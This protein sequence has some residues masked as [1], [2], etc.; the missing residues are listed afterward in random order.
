M[1]LPQHRTHLLILALLL[2]MI[3]AVACA[4][5]NAD[6]DATPL[7]DTGDYVTC[8]GFMTAEQIEEES[9]VSGLKDRV[10]VLDI[11][12]IPGLADSGAISNCLIDVY[13]T[14]DGNDSPA[15]GNSVSLSLVQFAT[16]EQALLLYNSTLAAAILTKEQVGAR[17]EVQQGVTG[18]DSYLMDVKAGGIGAIVVNVFDG[19][20]ISI[21][22][23]ADADRNAL[24]DGQG[25]I[26]AAKVVQSRLP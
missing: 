5:N 10:R 7:P 19:T 20:F 11:A 15:P 13:R 2:L 17:A 22:S 24:L 25:L 26:N 6:D 3:V 8:K 18:S 23:T 21:S 16:N 12:S 4:T 1:P 14:V 9:G